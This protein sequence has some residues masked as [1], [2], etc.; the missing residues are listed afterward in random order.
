[1]R[2]VKWVQPGLVIGVVVKTTK[3]LMEIREK[4]LRQNGSRVVAWKGF[5]IWLK[6]GMRLWLR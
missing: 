4:L 2:D 5:D 6:D 3:T 1:M